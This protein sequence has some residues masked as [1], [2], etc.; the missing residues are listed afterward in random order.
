[1]AHGTSHWLGAACIQPPSDSAQQETSRSTLKLSGQFF[2]RGGQ[3]RKHPFPTGLRLYLPGHPPMNKLYVGFTKSVE[4]PE[5]RLSGY[6]VRRCG[7]LTDGPAGQ[8]FRS[9]EA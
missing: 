2:F 1:M 9:P 8:D 7:L 6:S 5:M 3:L 4:V